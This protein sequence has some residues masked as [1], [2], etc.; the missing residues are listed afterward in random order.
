MIALVKALLS[1]GEKI[2]HEST[3]VAVESVGMLRDVTHVGR[4]ATKGMAVEAEIDYL[5]QVAQ[6]D[7]K[8]AEM[9][10]KLVDGKVVIENEETFKAHAATVA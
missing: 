4:Y 5:V 8:L 1:G 3:D 7:A 2:T 9:G 6:R 10:A